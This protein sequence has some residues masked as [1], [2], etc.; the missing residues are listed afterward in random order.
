MLEVHAWRHAPL[1]ALVRDFARARAYWQQ[2]GEP[3]LFDVGF[4]WSLKAAHAF[5]LAGML[6]R[7]GIPDQFWDPGGRP[8]LGPF[9]DR[10]NAMQN[11]G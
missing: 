2:T 5:F 9:C 1:P 7:F 10:I 6:H 3:V 11:A 4:P 8:A